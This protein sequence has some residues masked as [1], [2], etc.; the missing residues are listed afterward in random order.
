MSN[1]CYQST[2]EPATVLLVE[3]TDGD[4]RPVEEAFQQTESETT[5]HAVTTGADAM[6]FLTQ[7]SPYGSAPSPDLALLDL[8]LP[9]QTGHEVLESIR[10]TP[11]FRCLPV[12]IMTSSETRADVAA[13]YDAAANAYVTKPA[14]LAG[15]ISI[16]EAVEQF[17]LT[18]AELPSVPPS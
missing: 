3:D 12:I 4:V 13:C 5:L 1:H 9:E 16:V 8:S 7:Q 10:E 11:R 14:S 15:C 17:W 18:H 6:T 2:D